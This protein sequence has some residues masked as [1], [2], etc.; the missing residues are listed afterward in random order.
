MEALRRCPLHLWNL[1]KLIQWFLLEVQ[2]EILALSLLFCLR[3]WF[4][5]DCICLK[6]KISNKIHASLAS[7]CSR[8]FQNVKL[9]LDFVEIWSFY[10]HSEFTWNPIL[11]NSNGPKMLFL[12]IFGFLILILANLSNFQVPN[13]PKMKSS[14]SLELPKMTFLD[15][16]I[17][18]KFNFA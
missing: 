4:Q 17:S 14:E 2:K 8:N 15:H 18:P 16:L 9:R 5:N 11:A 3:Q 6:F 12:A 13:L 10:C 1:H 7:L